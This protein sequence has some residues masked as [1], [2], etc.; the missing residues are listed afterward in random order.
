MMNGCNDKSNTTKLKCQKQQV[1]ALG[2]CR[3]HWIC[4]KDHISELLFRRR[5]AM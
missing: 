4:C 5:G 3:R 2:P 1:T